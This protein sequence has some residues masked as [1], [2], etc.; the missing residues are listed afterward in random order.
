[1]LKTLPTGGR[2]FKKVRISAEIIKHGNIR[3]DK[4]DFI[5]KRAGLA[6]IPAIRQLEKECF[7]APWTYEQIEFEICNENSF[8]VAAFSGDELCGYGSFKYAADTAYI[9]NIAVDKRYRRQGIASAVCAALEEKAKKLSLEFITLEVRRSN[10]GAI[11]LYESRGYKNMGI[12]PNFYTSPVE[13]AVIM[14]A[15]SKK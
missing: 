4:M 8:F 13:D 1:M 11:A 5:I 14:T 10:Y 12:R 9:N 6:D 7:S 15:T 3:D 2:F